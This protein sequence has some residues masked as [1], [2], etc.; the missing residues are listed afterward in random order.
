MVKGVSSDPVHAPAEYIFDPTKQRI[1]DVF[2][3]FG[4]AAPYFL[5]VGFRALRYPDPGLDTG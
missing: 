1:A 5:G 2:G 4:P 3:R